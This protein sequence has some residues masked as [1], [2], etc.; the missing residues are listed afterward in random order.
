MCGDQR[1]AGLPCLYTLRRDRNKNLC[2]S[3]GQ[4]LAPAVTTMSL[5][6]AASEE[7]DVARRLCEANHVG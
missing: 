2:L 6:R 3:S 5:T 1:Y 7:L 4:I